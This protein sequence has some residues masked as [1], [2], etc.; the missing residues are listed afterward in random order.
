MRT[1]LH[2]VS[3]RDALG[4]R[5]LMQPV[6]AR[7]FRSSTP[8][9]RAVEGVDLDA[10]VA[11][12]RVLVEERPRSGTELAAALAE[13]WPGR[14]AT[15]M[16]Q[17]VR[18][19]LPMV[20]VTP[21]GLWSKSGLPRWTTTEAWL[22]S[23]ARASKASHAERLASTVRRYL[24]AFGPATVADMQTWSGLTGLRVVV[25]SLRPRLVTFRDEAG[26]ERFDLPDAPRPDG[27]TPAPPRLL[28]E[29]DNVLLSHRDRSHVI[30]A[31]AAPRLTGYV[32]TFL[33][34]GTVHGQWR[35]EVTR[36][37]ARLLL[38][39]FDQLRRPDEAALFEEAERYL[40]WHAP[41][42]SSRSV[43]VGRVR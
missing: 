40:A 5:P 43:E 7:T 24:A 17:A 20:Q 33:V 12:G 35:A 15:A 1:T 34:D 23:G 3:A 28:P 41:D 42:A 21:R 39:P 32:G 27:D 19:L 37:T 2:L 16:A 6:L 36:G 9:Y 4:L 13:G 11:R 26:R 29:Y 14:D 31:S 38:D 8:W 10:L 22:G 30:P 25:E 18:Y